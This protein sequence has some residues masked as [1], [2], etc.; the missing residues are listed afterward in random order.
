MNAP[1]FFVYFCV[2]YYLLNDCS[3]SVYINEYQKVAINKID[4][5]FAG[6]QGQKGN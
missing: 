2:N 3:C 5:M 6:V 4:C 1:D